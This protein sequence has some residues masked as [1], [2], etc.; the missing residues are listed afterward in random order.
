M[1][2][3]EPSI[4]PLD[5]V[6]VI[7]A[8]QAPTQVRIARLITHREHGSNLLLGAS[9]CDPGERTNTWSFEPDD[10][11]IGEDDHHYGEVDEF[12]YVLRGR[13]RLTWQRGQGADEVHGAAEFGA[14]DAVHLP[15]GWRYQLENIGD[16]PGFFIYG[17]SP[18]PH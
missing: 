13:F 11:A 10:R 7:P 16:E 6:P 2:V 18:S 3:Q 12:Y 17:M 14:D 4:V 1:T 9:W 5:T 8:D 15:P